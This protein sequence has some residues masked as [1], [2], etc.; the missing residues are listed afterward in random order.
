[1]T[2]IW[3]FRNGTLTTCRKWY[4]STMNIE[5]YITKYTMPKTTSTT[6][7]NVV[8]ILVF[9]RLWQTQ[10][11]I[12]FYSKIT[13]FPPFIFAWIFWWECL[14]KIFYSFILEVSDHA[15]QKKQLRHQ[16]KELVFKNCDKNEWKR[17]GFFLII[18]NTPFC[19][20][21]RPETIN[22]IWCKLKK[23]STDMYQN[24]WFLYRS[25]INGIT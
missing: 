4:F 2:K 7:C 8:L 24:W 22:H 15:R 12:D 5:K 9:C 6:V 14:E 21:I 1:M 20:W 25:E 16:P 18:F 3:F 19:Q 17:R 13:S 10:L 23:K 11:I